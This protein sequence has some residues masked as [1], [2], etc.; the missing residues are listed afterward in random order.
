M[1]PR[2]WNWRQWVAFAATVVVLLLVGYVGSYAV[3]YRR[4]VA[5]ADAFGSPFFFYAPLADVVLQKPNDQQSWLGPFYSPVN[6]LHIDW[7]GGRSQC[8][9]FTLCLSK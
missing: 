1:T 9:G 4:G 5:E 8:R 7:F 2:R 3:F 6:Y